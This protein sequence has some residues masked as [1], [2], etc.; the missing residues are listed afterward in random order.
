MV[1]PEPSPDG[2]ASPFASAEAFA[3]AKTQAMTRD[4]IIA[5]TEA[6]VPAVAEP[7]PAA[8]NAQGSGTSGTSGIGKASRATS[9][10]RRATGTASAGRR[11]TGAARRATA[12]STGTST[13]ARRKRQTG[14][15]GLPLPA[16][17]GIGAGVL[18]IVGVVLVL[19]LRG[20]GELVGSW[21]LDT[22]TMLSELKAKAPADANPQ[23][24]AMGEALLRAMAEQTN[25]T[26][27]ADG[28]GSFA[29]GPQR[30]DVTWKETE[31][32]GGR[33]VLAVT[34]KDGT[35]RVVAEFR[36]RKLVLTEQDGRQDAMIL[37]RR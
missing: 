8:G 29:M 9:A 30:D 15:R 2:S 19:L 10:V 11:A 14:R 22:E 20:G 13:S 24:Q 35:R 1:A 28:T 5:E 36:G 7:T 17:I 25:I 12:G 32:S 37:I 3:Q 6:A 18:A 31:R 23:L 34:G 4:R 21:Q 16:L 26:F 27:R 33:R